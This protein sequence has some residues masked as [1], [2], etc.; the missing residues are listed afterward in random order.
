M[1][2]SRWK[3]I[4][5]IFIILFLIETLIVLAVISI[6][7]DIIE[8]EERCEKDICSGSDVFYFDYDDYNE[9]C[10]CYDENGTEIIKRWMD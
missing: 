10:Y 9:M 5:I 7:Y 4:A 3:T 6:G 2:K 8:K 1:E